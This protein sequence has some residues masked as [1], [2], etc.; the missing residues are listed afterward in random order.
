[1]ID[2]DIE[3]RVLLQYADRHNMRNS[4]LV[5]STVG[6]PHSRVRSALAA[7]RVDPDLLKH[8]QLRIVSADAPHDPPIVSDSEIRMRVPGSG[9]VP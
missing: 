4:A 7:V 3:R 9:S 1:M 8:D 2:E 5:F 6:F